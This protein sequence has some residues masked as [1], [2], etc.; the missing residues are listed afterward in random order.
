MA[1]NRWEDLGP[2]L[3]SGLG[4][5]AAGLVALVA[6]GAWLAFAAAL[7]A[8]LLLWELAGLMAARDG[9]ESTVITPGTSGQGGVVLA[10]L[11]AA[12]VALV[13]AQ[14]VLMPELL[15]L[16]LPALAT[17]ALPLGVLP[18]GGQAD[19]Q[20]GAQADAQAGQRLLLALLALLIPVA[21]W[22]LLALRAESGV[23]LVLWLVTVV[24]VTDVAGYF[25]G[26]IL[27]GPRFWPRLSPKKTWSGT[28]AGWIG[29]ALAGWLFAAPL[30]AGAGIGAAAATG[31]GT[32]AGLVVL[33][34]L[35]SLAGQLGD[36]GQSALKRQAGV[37]DS[38]A[39]IPGHGGVWDRF[40]ALLAAALLLIAVRVVTGWPG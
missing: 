12:A 16:L 29:A 27:G 32:V 28:V 17:F 39:L 7:V 2:R 31:A 5:L 8:G 24:V 37:K 19:A 38:S 25:A 34:V 30:G 4:L 18:L 36:I 11:G 3:T 13:P 40:D 1:G 22:G 33:S 23:L 6:G 15:L 21:V 10:C 9:R 26:R 35:V 14:L 20:A